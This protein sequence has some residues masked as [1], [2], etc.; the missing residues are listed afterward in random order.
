[1]VAAPGSPA[2]HA[3]EPAAGPRRARRLNR[4]PRCPSS[5]VPCRWLI[6]RTCCTPCWRTWPCC[7]VGHN[8]CCACCAAP[9]CCRARRP[10]LSQARRRRR[11]AG[12]ASP[13]P[14]DLSAPRP[15]LPGWSRR[16]G[17][18]ACGCRGRPAAHQQGGTGE[19]RR[20]A[21]RSRRA[22]HRPGVLAGERGSAAAAAV[23]AAVPC[24]GAMLSRCWWPAVAWRLGG[25]GRAPQGH[26]STS[27]CCALPAAHPCRQP[28]RRRGRR[29]WRSN[30]ASQRWAL[31]ALRAAALGRDGV[32]RRLGSWGLPPSSSCAG[33][34]PAPASA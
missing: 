23:P 11:S 17:R 31:R 27:A 18:Q 16:P 15:Y 34:L 12:R 3:G 33:A 5:C 2:P 9:A 32:S 19:R 28:S 13:P 30:P 14:S 6:R 24:S 21:V 20:A 7:T 22:R 8:A 1:M 4:R 10:V 25:A 29:G 26:A